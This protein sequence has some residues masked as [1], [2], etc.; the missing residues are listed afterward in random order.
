MSNFFQIEVRHELRSSITYGFLVLR[1]N[2]EVSETLFSS[3]RESEAICSHPLAL[4]VYLL[5]PQVGSSDGRLHDSHAQLDELEETMGQHE[6]IGRPRGNPLEL[7][8]L[9]TTRSLNWIGNKIRID[10]LR[11]RELLVVLEKLGLW[12]TKVGNRNHDIEGNDQSRS[13]SS[14]ASFRGFELTSAFTAR[15]EYL[16]DSCTVLLF[17]AEYDER[18][19]RALIQVVGILLNS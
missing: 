18:R 12:E 16:K 2:N 3:M 15:L 13:T 7:D 1:R 8:F 5:E 17:E 19:V 11:L 10:I 4:L 9:S 6:Y 14:E